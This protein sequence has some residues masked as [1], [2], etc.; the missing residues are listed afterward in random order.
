MG[1]RCK[2]TM[3]QLDTALIQAESV[4][5]KVHIIRHLVI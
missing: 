5:F 4:C 1:E 2:E 3:K